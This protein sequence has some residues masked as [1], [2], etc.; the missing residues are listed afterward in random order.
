[1][2]FYSNICLGL[3]GCLDF[4]LFGRLFFLGVILGFALVARLRGVGGAGRLFLGLLADEGAEVRGV[5]AGLIGAGL[6]LGGRL[7]GHGGAEEAGHGVFVP[8]QELLRVDGVV[9]QI[10]Q[11]RNY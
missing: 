9:A 6:G 10:G 5:L 3:G 1:M 11:L 2:T 4:G 8:A 7:A